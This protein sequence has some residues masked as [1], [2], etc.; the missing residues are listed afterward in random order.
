MRVSSTV[1]V[2][3]ATF[4]AAGCN[5]AGPSDGDIVLESPALPVAPGST[6]ALALANG[7]EH[8]VHAGALPCT[9]TVEQRINGKWEPTGGGSPVCPAIAITID[10]G[11]R[12]EFTTQAPESL[13][14]FRFVTRVSEGNTSGLKI[15]SKPLS[16]VVFSY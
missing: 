1:L 15:Y 11:T 4:A 3:L 9:V 14:T 6:I 5:T 8:T 12:H 7:T 16:V 2:A 13:G 10:A